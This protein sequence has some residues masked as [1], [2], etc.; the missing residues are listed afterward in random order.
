MKPT[1]PKAIVNLAT[2]DQPF[3]TA[4]QVCAYLQV[5]QRT[6]RKWI[7][8]GYLEAMRLPGG[9]REWRIALSAL[10]TFVE[11]QHLAP[12]STHTAA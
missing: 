11:Q 10:R 7:E 5:D 6:M 9:K 3:V 2:H 4:R 1:H 8:G 12:A